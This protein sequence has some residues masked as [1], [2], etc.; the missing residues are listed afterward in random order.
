MNDIR[1]FL[2]DLPQKVNPDAVAGLSTLFHFDFGEAGQFTLQLADGK[3]NVTEGLSGEPRCKVATTAETF[4][5][6]LAGDLNPMMAMMTGKL[7]I[8]NPGEMLKYAK[9][10]G[11]A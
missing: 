7:K 10:F 4:A 6:L 3:L 5:K 2:F 9:I 8:S 11:L 1:Q